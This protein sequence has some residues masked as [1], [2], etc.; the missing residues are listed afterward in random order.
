M[1]WF[2]CDAKLIAKG[3]HTDNVNGR[4][5]QTASIT[6]RKTKKTSQINRL[7]GKIVCCSPNGL[8]G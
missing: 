7:G 2:G 8:L 5:V 3:L 1:H 4:G 6:R